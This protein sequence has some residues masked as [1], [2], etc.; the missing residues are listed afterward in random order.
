MVWRLQNT[1][2]V[3][4]SSHCIVHPQGKAKHDI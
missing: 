4:S 1:I 2:V 3:S